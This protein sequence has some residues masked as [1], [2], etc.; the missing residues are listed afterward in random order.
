MGK[1]MNAQDIINAILNIVDADELREVAKAVKTRDGEL[2]A[3]ATTD[4]KIGDRVMFNLPGNYEASNARGTIIKIGRWTVKVDTYS[5]GIWNVAI[6][7]IKKIP[8]TE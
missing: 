1:K 6:D 3:M 4:L 7:M 2:S 5:I 8:L